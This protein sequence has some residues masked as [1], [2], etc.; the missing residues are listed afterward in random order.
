MDNG[1]T[2]R[3]FTQPFASLGRDGWKDLLTKFK[4]QGIR[5]EQSEWR[6][7]HFSSDTNG[8][9]RSVIVMTLHAVNP[10]ANERFIVRGDLHVRWRRDSHATSR[11]F[12]E[13][14]D[15]T[16]L[17]LLSRQGKP[18]F[19][20]VLA[21]DITPNK[22]DRLT[23]PSLQLY[24]LDGDGLSEIILPG[25][26]HVF[27]NR[28]HGTF[29]SDVLL[30]HSV[31]SLSAGV[32]SDFDGDGAADFLG[33]NGQ[34]LALFRGDATGRF[35]HAPK[36]IRLANQRLPN[37]VV[38]TAGDIDRDNDLDV[39]LA[40]YKMPYKDGQMPTPFYDANDGY[41]AFLLVNDGQGN[42][43]DRTDQAGL[44]RKWHRR[45][46]SSSF[47]DLDHDSDLDLLVVSD[48][49]GVDVY[50]NDGKGHFTDVTDQTLRETHAFGMAH[51]FGDYHRDG[52]LDF[53]IIGMNSY[54]A[55][56]LD[57]LNAA[58]PEF[59]EFTRMRPRMAYGNRLYF[60]GPEGFR[61]T[62]VSDQVSRTGWSW[63]AT[64]GD[65]DN[66]GDQDICIVNGHISGQSASDYEPEF[67][68]RDI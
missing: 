41:P 36:R 16:R 38:I 56:R 1:I 2:S 14:I 42:F 3:R 20:R 13:S 18:P 33:A 65:F 40:Q 19:Q 25:R 44:A 35:L 9:A 39:W 45:T 49:A 68:R 7:P 61:Q 17:E 50:H 11:P 8:V 30:K 27:W 62:P 26:N 48:F 67:W 58:P 59:P 43:V 12:P 29:A 24:D 53:L 21:A 46:Y 31:S 34:G 57:G 66:D 15:A 64:T 28:G 10:E 32:I 60:R 5:L 6:H 55:N 22:T 51:T 54:V 4:Q 63:G 23:E 47:V 37:P 52:E